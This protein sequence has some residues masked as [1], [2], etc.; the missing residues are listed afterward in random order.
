[1][2]KW[3]FR[4]EKMDEENLLQ[5]IFEKAWF[6]E[7][8]LELQNNIMSKLESVSVIEHVKG[9]DREDIRFSWSGG[10]FYL[11]FECYSQS[12]WIEAEPGIDTAKII[13]LYELF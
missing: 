5:F 11:R 8:I 9:A 10:A 3:R 6:Q 1:M 12:C 2:Q 7:D 4:I 13:S